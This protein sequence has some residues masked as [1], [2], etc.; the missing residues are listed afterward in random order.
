MTIMRV[1]KDIRIPNPQ[2]KIDPVNAGIVAMPT[3]DP[4]K[5]AMALIK[6][7]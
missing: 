7:K 1:L 3:I 2:A 6:S 4:A 5:L